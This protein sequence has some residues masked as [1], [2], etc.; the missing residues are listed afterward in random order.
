MDARVRPT[1]FPAVEIGLSFFQALEAQSLQR[2]LLRVA[3]ARL[4]FALTIRIL[5]ATRHGN[6]TVVGEHVTV[7]RIQGGVVDVGDEHA[8][9]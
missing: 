7:E 4:D 8:L 2:R 6:G 1:F 5:D 9:A 3:H